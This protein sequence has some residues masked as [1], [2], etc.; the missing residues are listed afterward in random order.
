MCAEHDSLT[1]TSR[2]GFLFKLGLALNAIA[3]ALVGI[4]VIGYILG[5]V[6][7]SAGQEWIKLGVAGGLPQGQTPLATY[8]KPF[9][10]A[11][12]GPTPKIACWVRRDGGEQFPGVAGKRPPP[13]LPGGR[14]PPAP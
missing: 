4:P 2:R 10:V 7:R 13:R 6:R 1:T 9:P 11:W 5:P 12:G 3:A 14:V 8:E